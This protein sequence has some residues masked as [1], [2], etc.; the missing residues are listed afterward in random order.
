MRRLPVLATLIVALA[1][2]AM[3]ALGFWQIGRAHWKEA[4]LANYRAG[5]S[6][7]A[8]YGL[9]ADA[10]TDSL[11]FRRSHIVCRISTAP[12]Q[13]GGANAQGKTGFRN[14]VG[15]TLIDGRTI[16]VDIGWMP[17][18]AKPAL[19][20]A[21]QRIEADGLLVPGDAL[22]RRVLGDQPR[23]TPLLLVLEGAAPGLEPSVPPSIES[24]P[25]NHIAYAVQWFLFAAIA[26]IIYLLAL[27]RRHRRG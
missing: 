1:V 27:R 19:P 7:P 21:G 14:I 26:V 10:P 9:P 18:G 12:T 24:V 8:L 3:V 20:S 17:V 4:L 25:N 5:L 11:A 15:C 16:M 6:A 22:A 23:A 2:T 13:L